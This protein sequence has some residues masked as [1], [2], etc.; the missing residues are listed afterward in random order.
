MGGAFRLVSLAAVVVALGLAGCA[1][2]IASD[3]VDYGARNL[4][5]G[6]RPVVQRWKLPKAL[7]EVSGLALDSSGSLYAVA[8]EQAAVYRIDPAS[9][10][11]RSAYALG[12]P[13][14]TGDFEGIALADEWLYLVTSD[15]KL[16]RTQ[17]AADGKIASYETFS[18]PIACEVEGLATDPNGLRLWLVC[19][20]FEDPALSKQLVRMHAWVIAD[21][22]LNPEQQLN[23]DL[24]E[25]LALTNQHRFKPSGIA[26]VPSSEGMQLF[27]ISGAQRAFARWRW[28]DNAVQ[29]VG[30]ARLPKDHKQAEGVDVAP[31]GGILIADEGGSKRARLRWYAPGELF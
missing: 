23:L 2:P 25:V 31:D 1:E 14:L 3:G 5:A 11:I 21:K 18:L 4:A 29:F 9:G 22:R 24:S 16:V 27:I 19:K 17:G 30:A 28:V 26:F 20:S 10:K 15:G 6:E 8:D 13:T 12:K 7:R